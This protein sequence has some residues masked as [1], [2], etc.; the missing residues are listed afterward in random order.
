MPARIVFDDQ[1]DNSLTCYINA[2][3]KLYIEIGS[4]N[5]ELPSYIVLNTTDVKILIVELQAIFNMMQDG[6]VD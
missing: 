1:F 5:F 4:D 6:W 2:D 3:N